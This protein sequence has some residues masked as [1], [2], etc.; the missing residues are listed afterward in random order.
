[1]LV[2]CAK[3]YNKQAQESVTRNSHMNELNTGD[4]LNP[5]HTEAVLVD[6]INFVGVHQG[7]DLAL[8]TSDIK[9]DKNG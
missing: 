2:T 7:I 9:P 8:Y 5:K 4:V 6:F 1:M 3:E